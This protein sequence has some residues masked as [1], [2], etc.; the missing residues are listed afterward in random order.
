MIRAALLA[1]SMLFATP[2]LSQDAAMPEHVYTEAPSDRTLGSADAPHTLI[3]Y[4]SNVCPHCG[5]WFAKEWPMVKRD[6]IETG[7][8]RFVFRPLPSQPIQLSMMGFIMAEC[9][10]A[11]DYFMVI[12]D[13]FARQ[14]AILQKLYSQQGDLKADYDAIAKVAGLADDAA[15]AT[16][17]SDTTHS[18]TLKTSGARAG[19]AGISG[20]PAFIFDGTVMS[21]KHDATAIKG[22]M[23]G[24]ST[25]TQ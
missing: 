25:I 9:A 12:E 15:I 19:A 13:Q 16:C 8:L 6:M 20:I 7:Q 2:A 3:M 24:R 21:G 10:P 11:E 5:E 17:L 22:W 4:A 18:E 1:L 14:D 23:Q